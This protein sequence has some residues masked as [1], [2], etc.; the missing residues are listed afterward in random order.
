M[1]LSSDNRDEQIPPSTKKFRYLIGVYESC[2]AH[3]HKRRDEFN[4][5]LLLNGKV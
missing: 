4:R 1:A 5:G 2:G 3:S